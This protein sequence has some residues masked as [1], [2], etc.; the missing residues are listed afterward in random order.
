CPTRRSSDLP[1][2]VRTREHIN[3]HFLVC[4]VAL[5][6]LRILEFKLGKKYSIRRIRE[7]LIEYS[8]T[9][10]EQNIHVFNYRDEIL[11]SLEKIFDLN[12][13]K[14]YMSTSEIKKILE[15]HK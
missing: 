7:S 2:F 11:C 9:Y 13:K 6:I 5:L 3:A 15:Y 8:C 12:L 4:F 10:I 14:K 1:I